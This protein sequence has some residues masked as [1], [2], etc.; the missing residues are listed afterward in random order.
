MQRLTWLREEAQG[1][2]PSRSALSEPNGLLAIGGDLSP[3]RLLDAYGRGIFPW[4]E[5][6]QPILWWTPDPRMVLFPNEVHCSRSMAK[7]LRKCPWQVRVDQDFHA[8][9]E[10]CS[11]P[12]GDHAGTWITDSMKQAYL[13]LHDLGVAHSIEVIE[14]GNLIGGMY[15]VGLGRIFFGESMFSTRPNASKVAMIT[16]A[17]WLAQNHFALID[18]QVTSAHLNSMG[19]REISR[20]K[21]EHYLELNTTAGLVHSMQDVW[22]NS[23]GKLLGFDGSIND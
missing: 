9:I 15:G 4:F 22:R 14:D 6:G 19:A 8:V 18:C 20:A 13:A 3:Q 23:I 16:L 5:D 2:P 17:R 7:F 10:A 1:F 12:R 11:G 21:F